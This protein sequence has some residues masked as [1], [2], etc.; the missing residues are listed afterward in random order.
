MDWPILRRWNVPWPWQTVSL[1]SLACGIR[2]GF[3]PCS[4]GLVENRFAFRICDL[5]SWLMLFP[6]SF[7]LTGLIETAALP[8][9]GI[10]IG[11]LTMDE[12]AELLFLG[13]R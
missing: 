1:T 5:E 3:R 12:K 7:V 8:Y 11:E 4:A 2:F 6:G 9:L 10:Q 13:Q